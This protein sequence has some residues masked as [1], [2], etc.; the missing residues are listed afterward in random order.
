[1]RRPPVSLSACLLL[2]CW[3]WEGTAGEDLDLLILHTNDMHARFEETN[4]NSGT[5]SRPG[6]CVG[7]FARVAHVVRG[8]RR[9]A[10]EG[11]GRQVLFLNAG[12]TFTGTV[13]FGVHK[14]RIAVDFMNLLAPDAMVRR[15][16]GGGRHLFTHSWAS[17]VRFHF[18]C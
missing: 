9:A 1:M 10:R 7:G 3:F 2:C 15:S 12:D 11:R 16:F 17:A 14:T 18:C 5:C 13:W 6:S 8:A 4:R